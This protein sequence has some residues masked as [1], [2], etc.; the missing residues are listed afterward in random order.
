[1]G[2]R[3][4]LAG[5][6]VRAV[7]Q[8]AS[9]AIW[10]TVA[11]GGLHRIEGG[12]DPGLRDPRRA[13]VRPAVGPPRRPGRPALGRHL[14]GRPRR[15]QERRF[16][17]VPLPPPAFASRDVR[18]LAEDED[19]SVWVGL[20]P[21]GVVRLREGWPGASA[22]RKAFRRTASSAFSP[23]VAGASGRGRR[24]GSPGS[25]GTASRPTRD[26]TGFPT[27]GSRPSCWTTRGPSGSARETGWPACGTG[28]SRASARRTASS[29]AS[30][31]PSCW[32][33]AGSS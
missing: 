20:L 33:T 19:G 1:M 8:D 17:R 14:H 32:T 22:S 16:T 3:E 12:F 28:R 27:T 9:G 15:R 18:A 5:E 7:T 26:A 10:A 11:S 25:T 30:S 6:N 29:T 24:P 23:P 31:R 13:P 2:T 4:G 21:G